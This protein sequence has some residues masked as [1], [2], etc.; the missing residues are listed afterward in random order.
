MFITPLESNSYNRSKYRIVVSNSAGNA[1][2]NDATLTVNNSTISATD[3]VS[4]HNDVARTGQ[5]LNE[6]VLTT[7]NVNPTAFGKIASLSV[8]GKVD[9]QTLYLANVQNIGGGTHNVLYVAT[10]HDSVYAFDAD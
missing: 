8:D 2:S 5:N 10:E 9:A 7:A 6:T 1:T 3:V 4:Y